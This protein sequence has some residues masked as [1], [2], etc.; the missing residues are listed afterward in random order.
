M[1]DT[2]LLSDHTEEMVAHGDRP[3]RDGGS[4]FAPSA[5]R[6]S[7]GTDALLLL[8]RAGETVPAGMQDI[9]AL[10]VASCIGVPPAAV[11]VAKGSGSRRRLWA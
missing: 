2:R 7:G 5:P 10:S 1:H 4:V 6:R 11:A 8:N 3:A 9:I